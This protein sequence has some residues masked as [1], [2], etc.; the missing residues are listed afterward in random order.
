MAAAL[1]RPP[2]RIGSS[3]SG[4]RGRRSSGPL[5]SYGPRSSGPPEIRPS[6]SDLRGRP[7]SGPLD[8]SGRRSSAPLE[9]SGRLSTSST[10]GNALGASR[11]APRIRPGT[12]S[13][14]V[15]RSRAG[16]PTRASQARRLNELG[17]QLRRDGEYERAAEQHR[18][19]LAIVRDLGRPAHRSAH[20][21][22]SRAGSRPY[23]L[24]VRRRRALRAGARPPAGARR[25]EARGTGDRKPR[26][27][28]PQAGS[29]RRREEPPHCSARQAP[30]GVVRVPAASKSSS[31]ARAE[32]ESA[33]LSSRLRLS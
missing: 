2:V 28:P 20:A 17:A 12:P 32:V 6:T 26:L 31:D 3:S 1:A 8:S 30:P 7:S 22:Q 29:R 11:A 24:R 18:A 13:K 25:R 33:G 14:F 15:R 19:A 16:R 10:P 4:S 5:E 21:E 9:R 23:R 27:R